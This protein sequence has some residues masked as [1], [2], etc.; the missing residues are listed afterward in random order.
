MAMNEIYLVT[1]ERIDGWPNTPD[2]VVAFTD[3]DDALAYVKAANLY[4]NGGTEKVRYTI[5]Q[6]EIELNPTLPGV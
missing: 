1:V 4:Y 6:D 5:Y 3:Y 2:P